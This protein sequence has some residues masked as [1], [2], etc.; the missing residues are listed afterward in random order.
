[1]QLN[2]E[3]LQKIKVAA[4]RNFDAYL[5]K[6]L[7]A[8]VEHGPFAMEMLDRLHEQLPRTSCG[9]C[10]RCCNSV[11][12]F[13]LE[14]HRIIREVMATWQPERLRRLIKSAL[15]FDLRQADAGGEKR[16]RCI[17]RDDETRVCLIHPVRPFACRIYGL[18][19]EDGTRT[20]DQ[21]SDL[22]LPARPVSESYLTDL[23]SR[24]LENSESFEPFPATGKIHF[25][26]F[27]FWF[28]RHIFTP[29][30]AMQIYREILVPM[31]TPL[32]RLWHE[33]KAVPELRDDLYEDNGDN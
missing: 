20:C 26:P 27:E 33:Q 9:N 30:R 18:L 19:Q 1:M 25:F 29:E 16:L 12:I 2:T 7:S 17:F 21:V 23:Q 4:A 5:Q 14:Y 10:G 32:T 8:S 3:L 15:R 22:R 24:V 31:S 6:A 28:F 13:S 11:S